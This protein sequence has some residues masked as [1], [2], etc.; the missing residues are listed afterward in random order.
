MPVIAPV[1]EFKVETRRQRASGDGPIRVGWCAAGSR[2][3]L[4]VGGR[5]RRR[6]WTSR[7]DA[8]G[9]WIYGEGKRLR[10]RLRC[11]RRVLYLD[12]KFDVAV[13]VGV[14]LIA[15]V[16]G[17]RLRPAGSEPVITVQLT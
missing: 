14:P 3:G 11:S 17:F 12:V 10:G 8:Q 5:G 7:A 13:V 2:Q 16:A 4:G 9:R 6:Q 15:P 1:E